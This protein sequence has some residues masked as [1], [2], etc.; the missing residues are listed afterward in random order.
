MITH[1]LLDEVPVTHF[2]HEPAIS[3]PADISIE[4]FVKDYVYATHADFYPVVEGDRLVGG[5]AARQ[6][7]RVPKSRWRNLSVAEVMTPLSP[8][9]VVSPAADVAQALTAMRR[10]GR[11]HVM[12]AEG[13][14]LRGVVAF[15]ELQRYLSFKLEI[16]QSG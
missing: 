7:R 5:L 11:S 8:D 15:S 4:S 1:R 6:L 9:T 12:V 14:K 13:A 16:E 2:L 10:T 3:V